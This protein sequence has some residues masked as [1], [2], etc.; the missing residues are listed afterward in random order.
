MTDFI[1]RC[2]RSLEAGGILLILI[3]VLFTPLMI[4]RRGA[5]PPEATALFLARQSTS[6]VAALLLIFGCL[7]IHLVQREVYGRLGAGAFLA[8]FVGGCLLFAV[9]WGNVFLVQPVARIAPAAFAAVDKDTFSN[10]GFASAA[11]LFALGWLAL[12]LTTWRFGNLSRPAA[13]AT[14]VGILSIPIL[15]ALFKTPGAIL[16]NAI[17]GAGL[18]ALGRATAGRDASQ[19]AVPR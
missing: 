5:G 8:A 3:N 9:E 7:G 16:G 2:G 15:Q 14:F 1:R 11:G 10:L 4:S 19:K 18:T 17:F 12:S 6:A 13:I